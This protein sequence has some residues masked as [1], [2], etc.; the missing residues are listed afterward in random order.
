MEEEASRLVVASGWVA[1]QDDLH[2]LGLDRP[3]LL[4]RLRDASRTAATMLGEH[5]QGSLTKLESSIIAAETKTKRLGPLLRDSEIEF[6]SAMRKLVTVLARL[7]RTIEAEIG[8]IKRFSMLEADPKVCSSMASGL[9]MS[10]T[11]QYFVAV[12]SALVF[13]RL[14]GT[15][16][17][18]SQEYKKHQESLKMSLSALNN[19][20]EIAAI[21]ALHDHTLVAQMRREAGVPRRPVRQGCTGKQRPQAKFEAVRKRSGLWPSSKRN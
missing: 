1:W 5:V 21:E 9:H 10:A 20:D 18:K 11:L 7:Q 13:Y 6:S 16:N 2:E 19:S 8:A 4:R 12:H 3:E 17:A 14:P 15:W